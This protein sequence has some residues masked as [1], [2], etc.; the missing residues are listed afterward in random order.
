MAKKVREAACEA[1]PTL[2]SG[3]GSFVPVSIPTH[4]VD[5]STSDTISADIIIHLGSVT[6]ELHNNASTTLIENAL[7]ALQNVR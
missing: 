5:I 2:S 7:R 3:H 6:M 4:T 1:L